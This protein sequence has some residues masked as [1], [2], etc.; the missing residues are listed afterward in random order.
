MGQQQL[1]LLVL[2][3]VIVGLAVVA[4]INAFDENQQ[5]SSEDALTNEAFRLASDAKA[6]YNKPTQYDGGGS[7]ASNISEMEWK[8]IGVQDGSLSDGNADDLSGD[9]ETPWGTVSASTSSET[10][11]FSLTTNQG[12]DTSFGTVTFD[13]SL[14][15]GDQIQFERGS[16]SSSSGGSSG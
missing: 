1:L 13:P 6:W 3:I 4:G 15:A 10:V 16:S 9:Y 2:G 5:K 11:E 14:D 7:D 8:D 12:D